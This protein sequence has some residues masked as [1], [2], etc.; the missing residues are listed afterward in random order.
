MR[1][2]K[3]EQRRRAQAVCRRQDRDNLLYQSSLADRCEGVMARRFLHDSRTK[4]WAAQDPMTKI[5]DRTGTKKLLDLVELTVRATI[6]ILLPEEER[7]ASNMRF[8]K[9]SWYRGIAQILE[10]RT[11]LDGSNVRFDVLPNLLGTPDGV[12]DLTSGQ[13]ADASVLTQDHVSKQT[14]VSPAPG[15]KTPIFD[16]FLD[17]LVG[18]DENLRRFLFLILG[19]WLTGETREQLSFVFLGQSDTGKNTLLDAVASCMGDYATARRIRHFTEKQQEHPHWLA[20]LEGARLCV[21][22]QPSGGSFWKADC[23]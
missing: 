10:S 7:A 6:D 13:L 18:E 21:S 16:G 1:L 20:E 15:M 9:A 17:H 8:A 3:S 5:W 19:Y 22:Q 2:R 11:A 14:S 23:K 12:F 4:Q